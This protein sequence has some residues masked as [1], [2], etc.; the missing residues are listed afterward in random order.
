MLNISNTSSIKGDLQ[1]ED[2]RSGTKVAKRRHY[3]YFNRFLGGAAIFAFIVLFLP[4]TQ[5]VTGRGSVTTLTPESRP[6]TIQSPIAGR[7]EQWYVREGQKVEL[8]DTILRISEVKSEYFDDRLVE[9]TTDQIGSKSN[10]VVSY[11]NKVS[12]LANQ[13]AAL[14]QERELK[15]EQADLKLQQARLGVESDSIDLVAARTNERIALQQLNRFIELNEE[16]FESDQEVEMKEMKY[17]ESQSKRISQE[18]KLLQSRAKVADALVE[19][20]RVNQEYIDK[21]SKAESDRFTAQSTQFDTEAQVS[22]LEVDRA[23]YERRRDLYYVTAPQAGFVN[24]AIIG[25][26]GETFKEGQKLVDIMPTEYELAVETFVEPID[27]P[28]IHEGEEVRVQFDG[29]PAIVFSGWPAATYG[30]YGA[31]VVAV[32]QFID[33]VKGKYRVLLAPDERETEWPDQL[34]PGAGAYTIALLEDVPVW[35]ELWRRLN[36]FPANFYQPEEGK[37]KNDAKKK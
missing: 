2:Y 23:N 30:T 37:K 17:Q 6:Q 33:P 10:A 11:Q 18:A 3:K 16:G 5:N 14:R 25:G 20:N 35:Y 32:S 4:W 27:L 19:I 8:G 26:I 21:I 34:V 22:K 7:I 12:S 1:L 28:L 36:G 31:R 9:R 13:I 15:L 29:W 24:L